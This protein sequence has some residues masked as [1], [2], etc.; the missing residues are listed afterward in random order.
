VGSGVTFFSVIDVETKLASVFCPGQDFDA[1]LKEQVAWNKSSLLL[2]IILQTHK[3]Y[4][5]LQR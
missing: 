4:N 3:H 1:H 5:Y 2:K